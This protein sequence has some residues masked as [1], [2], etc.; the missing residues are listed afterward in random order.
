MSDYM[1]NFEVQITAC[2]QGALKNALKMA[3]MRYDRAEAW[4][5]VEGW[6]VLYWMKDKDSKPIITHQFPTKMNAD[7]VL[8]IISSWLEEKEI[9]EKHPDIDGSCSKGFELTTVHSRGW[10]YEICRIRPIWA[11]HHK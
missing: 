8:P 2:S 3:L 4:A 7:T 11:M 9:S 1:D 5:E 6:L 10:S